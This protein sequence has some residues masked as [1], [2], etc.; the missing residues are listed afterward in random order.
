MSRPADLTHDLAAA[1]FKS[2]PPLTVWF[3]T[4]NEW[5]AVAGIIWIILQAAYLARKW[6][7]EERAKRAPPSD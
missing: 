3:L 5:L 7:R 6:W 4:L 2:L 1:T